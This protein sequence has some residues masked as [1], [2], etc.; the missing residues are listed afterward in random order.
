MNENDPSYI[1]IMDYVEAN[2]AAVLSTA[3]KDG[4]PHGAVIYVMVGSHGTLCFVTK[5]KTRK[6]QNILDQPGIN[7]TFFNEK[8]SS[9]L[10]VAGRAFVADSPALQ[11]MIL[12]KMKALHAIRSEWVPP[13]TKVQAG[14]FVVVGVEI[15]SARLTSFQGMSMDGSPKIIEV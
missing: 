11:N 2:P 10:Q 8:D 6:F 14:D 9:T 15:A 3:D 7:L 4:T 13:V 1:K 12:D 5:N